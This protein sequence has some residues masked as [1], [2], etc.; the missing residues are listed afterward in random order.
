M[1]RSSRAAAAAAA[2]AAIYRACGSYIIISVSEVLCIACCAD[3]CE[4]SILK[5]YFTLLRGNR[6]IINRIQTVKRIY[7]EINIFNS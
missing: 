1:Q 7:S 5:K 3:R 2:A 6:P 4:R